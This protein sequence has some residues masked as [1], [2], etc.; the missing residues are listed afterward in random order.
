MNGR[1]RQKD[2]Q[3]RKVQGSPRGRAAGN[4]E[5]EI[6]KVRGSQLGTLLGLATY[7]TPGYMQRPRIERPRVADAY[8][9]RS[10]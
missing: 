2:Q 9:P 6:R 8:H 10:D 4:T 3:W 7:F 1:A 5:R